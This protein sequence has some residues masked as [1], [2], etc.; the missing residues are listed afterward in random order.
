[1]TLTL[2]IIGWFLIGAVGHIIDRY[3]QEKDVT[4]FLLIMCSWLGP[5]EFITAII[6]YSQVKD[7]TIIKWNKK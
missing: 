7:I 5:I 4:I 2:I 6:L 1:M 3:N